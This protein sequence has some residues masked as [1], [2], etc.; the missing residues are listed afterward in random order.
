MSDE[1]R[2]RLADMRSFAKLA[3]RLVGPMKLGEFI[4]DERTRYAVQYLLLVIGE[5]SI[6]VPSDAKA[7]LV[8]VPWPKLQGLR[9]RLAHAYFAVEAATVYVAVS[10]DLPELLQ[11]LEDQ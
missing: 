2:Q 4:E 8:N 10:K 9:N 5:A 11:A 3:H 6:H 7:R 1:A